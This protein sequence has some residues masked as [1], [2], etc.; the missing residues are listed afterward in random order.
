MW[1]LVTLVIGVSFSGVVAPGP[2]FAVTLAKSY[3]SPWAGT[4][5]ALGHAVVE[6]PLI[7]LIYFGFA[8]FFQN[9]SVQIVLSLV[10]GGMIVWMGVG[11]YL[12][13]AR[14]V[15]EGKDLPYPTLVAGIVMSV[16]N[17]FFLLWWATAGSLLVIKFLAYG[18]GGLFILIA[19]HWACD[20]VWLSFVAVFINRT[21]HF[22]GKR[23][24]EWLFIGTSLFL[25][26]FGLRFIIT[27]IQ[28]I[29]K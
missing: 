4:L 9:N 22:L 3:R 18:I 20:L 26:A 5:M 17:P 19:V 15:D 14:V 8:H 29:I 10:G 1:A 2:F 6:I 16:I 25:L 7:F 24:Q 11:M 12:D 27:G 13:R 28:A 23:F 21:H